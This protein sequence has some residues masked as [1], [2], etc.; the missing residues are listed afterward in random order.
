MTDKLVEDI[1]HALD[2]GRN[3]L[4]WYTVTKDEQLMVDC[5]DWNLS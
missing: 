1:F 3:R 4:Q 2:M 5:K